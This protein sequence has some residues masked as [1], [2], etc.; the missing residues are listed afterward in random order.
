ME[1]SL[2]SEDTLSSLMGDNGLRFSFA[3]TDDRRR[4]GELGGEG[5]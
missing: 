5:R 3:V 4:G 2:F 1:L